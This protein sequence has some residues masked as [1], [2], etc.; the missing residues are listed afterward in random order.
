MHIQSE[1]LASISSMPTRNAPEPHAESTTADHLVSTLNPTR[2]FRICINIETF[3]LSPAD[4]TQN[5]RELQC[6]TSGI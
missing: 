5:D 1:Q 4:R 2:Y 3:S 6:G